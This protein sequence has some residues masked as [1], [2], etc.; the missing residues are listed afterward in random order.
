MA[1]I[2]G[3]STA[4]INQVDGFFTTQGG[5]LFENPVVSSAG[6]QVS[7]AGTLPYNP[8]VVM[9]FNRSPV[10]PYNFVSMAASGQYYQTL[11]VRDD[12]TLWGYVLTS[13]WIQGMGFPLGQWAQ[14]G[15]DTDWEQVDSAQNGF[16]FIKGGAYWYV[17]YG[18]FG[19]RGDGSTSNVTIPTLTN[20]SFTWTKLS[21][22]AQH[23]ALLNSAGEVYTTGVNSSYGTGLGVTSGTTTTLTREQ[24]N[25]TGVTD[26]ASA[27]QQI[28]IVTGGNIYS[29]GNNGYLCAGPLISLTTVD[30]P[31]LGYNGGDIDKIFCA[32]DH[33]VATTTSGGVRHAGEGFGRRLDNISTDLVGLTG[34]PNEQFTLLTA[35][36]TGWTYYEVSNTTSSTFVCQLAI[37][38]G[39]VYGSLDS[40]VNVWG[41][42]TP[43]VYQR[44][45]TFSTAT[46]VMVDL[47]SFA[48]TNMA[49]QVT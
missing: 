24:T 25:L 16:G 5:G 8:G 10:F 3:Q 28:K 2:S 49:I 29:T 11:A 36:G 45:G 9:G 33:A 38:N 35:A 46:V 18:P 31:V 20:N 15:T 1:S 13:A 14:Y 30:G 47:N 42:T 19:L 40:S 7:G 48:T 39:E 21:M 22:G 27:Y 26:I 23:L 12:G 37:K 41:N 43:F 4:N 6:V 17:G 44:I 32:R 34:Q